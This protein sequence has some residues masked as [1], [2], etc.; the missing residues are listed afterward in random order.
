MHLLLVPQPHGVHCAVGSCARQGRPV[1]RK[2]PLLG[3]CS[4][5]NLHIPL[6][7][8]LAL[9]SS[10]PFAGVPRRG[11][12]E[13][14]APGA[15][16]CRGGCLP[17][18]GGAAAGSATHVLNFMHYLCT[19]TRCLPAENDESKSILGLQQRQRCVIGSCHVAK[20]SSCH[21]GRIRSQHLRTGYKQAA[22]MRNVKQVAKQTVLYAKPEA[23][24][25]HDGASTRKKQTCGRFVLLF[26]HQ[27]LRGWT[28]RSQAPGL[29]S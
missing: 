22:H 14:P 17:A 21:F 3:K 29:P 27:P 8:A 24:E 13:A 5:A 25:A 2:A 12:A 10:S 18:G 28:S 9:C 15:P 20:R 7:V 19:S 4:C 11:A 1:Y 26:Q 16:E 6:N 23:Q